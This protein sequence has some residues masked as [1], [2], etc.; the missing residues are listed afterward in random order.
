MPLT[1]GNAQV[2]QNTPG[3]AALGG[4]QS[5]PPA[6]PAGA[7]TIHSVSV[8]ATRVAFGSGSLSAGISSLYVVPS[9]V[10]FGSGALTEN[11]Y[12]TIFLDGIPYG[13]LAGSVTINN[14]LSQPS[15]ASFALWDPTGTVVPQVGQDVQIY[16][17]TDRI[18][19][20]TVEQPFGTGFQALPGHLYSGSG[21]AGAGVSSATASGGS[22]SGG[23]GGVQCNDYSLLLARRYIGL[24]FDGNGAPVPS[25]L[26]D[27]VEYIV[28][29]Y[30]AQDGFIYDDSDGDPNINLG[31][32]LFNWVTGA[33]AFNTL[34]TATGWEWSVDAFKVIR[35]YPSANGTAVA[36]FNIADNDGHVYAESLGVSYMRSQYRNKQGVISPTATGQ[37]W[38]DVF[39]VSQPGPFANNPQPPDGT[40][41]TFLQLYGFTVLPK[42]TVNGN[43]QTVV[44]LSEISSTP[45]WQ[46]YI[47]DP[48]IV[49]GAP[50]P[51]YGL[52]QN[53][54]N[55]PLGIFDTLI[56]S[57][58]TPL[59]PIYWIQNDAQI[60]ERAAIEGNSGVYEDV[61]QA[62]S[63]AT[64]EAIQAYAAGLLARY[65]NGIPYQVTYSTRLPGMATGPLM[66]GM[67]QE[68]H[69]ANPD[70]NFTGLISNV[71]WQDIDGQFMN[72][73]V[74][75]LSGEYQGNFTQ[76]FAALI[77]QGQAP[78]PQQAVTNTYQFN[79]A[80]TVPGLSN[81]GVTGGYTSPSAQN[82]PNPVEQI[83]TVQV[84]V[85]NPITGAG[86]MSFILLQNAD[87]IITLTFDV[88]QDGT[89]TY[90]AQY[91]ATLNLFAG[92][93]LRV[94]VGGIGDAVKDVTVTITTIIIPT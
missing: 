84:H 3:W 26:S 77:T 91:F 67:L 28:Q 68:I 18:F 52:F 89:Q 90:Y 66:A 2:G 25:L 13:A 48:T 75:V 32:Q 4:Y 70:L 87:G 72:L 79:I 34:S 63:A 60:A 85:P 51:S 41:R 46:W 50:L 16:I 33:A 73:S 93:L 5:P 30:F 53:P 27:I 47:V 6:F 56:I 23:S 40:R 78:L 76:F 17:G 10:A 58:P 24:Y 31:A 80:P 36:P 37:L 74:T 45:G 82:V 12:I 49:N 57:Y 64:Q 42:V 55:A 43:A 35:F 69:T 86:P 39:S 21:G 14:P 71:T 61:E 94:Q 38:S 8:V 20:G 29:Q 88:G 44:L 15:T 81:P 22:G 1:L 54:S 19:G 65:G 7:N 9:R 83:Q 59:T 62:P 92:D 11:P